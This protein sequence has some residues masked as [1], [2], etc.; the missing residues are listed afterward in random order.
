MDTNQ[1]KSSLNTYYKRLSF[2][3]KIGYERALDQFHFAIKSMS[4]EE[5][6]FILSLLDNGDTFDISAVRSAF[7]FLTSWA[8][9]GFFPSQSILTRL[10]F[11]AFKDPRLFPQIG[12]FNDLIPNNGW[13][14]H[15]LK[16]IITNHFSLFQ[17]S[18]QNDFPIWNPL[19]EIMENDINSKRINYQE[20]YC[21]RQHSFLCEVFVLFF[22]CSK[23]SNVDIESLVSSLCSYMCN[24][25]TRTAYHIISLIA[26]VF[27]KE[28]FT[29]IKNKNISKL[30]SKSLSVFNTLSLLKNFNPPPNEIQSFII[31]TLGFDHQLGTKLFSNLSKEKSQELDEISKYFNSETSQF[32]LEPFIE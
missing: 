21:N 9:I 24:I 10:L 4:E 25:G 20:R 18:I 16:K 32:F 7:N 8:D 31:K 3:D 2:L 28:T 19:L 30:S 14:F 17:D 22:D 26:M 13:L 5:N 23:T 15:A 1:L 6:G 29:E 11:Y 27:P 12:F